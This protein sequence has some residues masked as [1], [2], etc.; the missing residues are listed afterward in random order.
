[1]KV[2]TAYTGDG[3]HRWLN[4]HMDFYIYAYIREDGSPYY[5]GKGRGKRAWEKYGH[6][7]LRP[8]DFRRIVLL[9]TN[10][11][12]VG[13]FALERRLIE[14]WGRKDIGTGILQNRT[15]GGEGAMGNIP[16]N[17]GGIRANDKALQQVVSI[18]AAH[19]EVT[20]PA[21]QTEIVYN[22]ANYCREHGLREN[23]MRYHPNRLHKGFRCIRVENG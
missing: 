13:A 4:S 14:W 18:N 10:L 21:G 9:E 20:S 12:E 11:T 5:I 15:A 17:K 6:R 19:W 8:S 1:M 22:L 3:R 2:R 16:W 23:A 7:N